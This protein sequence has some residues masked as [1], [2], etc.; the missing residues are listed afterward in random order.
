MEPLEA[1]YVV[2]SHAPN[3]R[4]LIETARTTN[5]LPADFRRWRKQFNA[6]YVAAAVR[7]AEARRRGAAKFKRAGSMWLDR[8]G[9][10]QA[11]AEEVT[12]H[13]A[14]RF[15]PGSIVV[16]LCSGVGGDAL[17]I[18]ERAEGVI[19]VDRDPGMS[20]RL[21]WNASVYM[22][23]KK[24]LPVVGRAERFPV[25]TGALVHIDPDRRARPGK[26]RALH[27][28]DY[29]P[30]PENLRAITSKAPGG[31]IKLGPASDF[32]A[33]ASGISGAD[34]EVEVI[35]LHGEC[36]EAT[37]W[38]G[39]LAGVDSR[40]TMLPGKHTWTGPRSVVQSDRCRSE[41]LRWVLEPD[42]ALVRAGL[43]DHF[44]ASHDL[45]FLDPMIDWLT[46]S[47]RVDSPF[48]EAFEV[49]EVVPLEK[50]RIRRALASRDFRVGEIKTRGLG[51]E[52]RPEVIR[53]SLEGGGKRLGVLL[54]LGGSST[55]R[56]VVARRIWSPVRDEG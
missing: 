46:S 44:A 32:E 42:P 4:L 38:F 40:A 24:M 6:D 47:T 11:T 51:P 56:A 10:E 23:G 21:A 36:K 41:V 37:L 50:K 35:S 39:S 31:A 30:G 54:L 2:L 28:G 12:R 45:V 26:P 8:V 25:P 22:V 17:A 55:G 13:K 19:A 5:P 34:V 43:L 3:W 29:V 53:K 52:W 48:L 49:E 15:P 7:L 1:E 14:D 33:F 18:A 27:L 16:D 9:V 20:R